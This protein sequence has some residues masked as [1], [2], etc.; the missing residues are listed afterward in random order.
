MNNNDRKLSNFSTLYFFISMLIFLVFVQS[1]KALNDNI[2]IPHIVVGFTPLMIVMAFGLF[3][4]AVIVL[5]KGKVLL[6]MISLI[7][8]IR[9]IFPLIPLVYEPQASEFVGNYAILIMD[10]LI[11]LIAANSIVDFNGLKKAILLVFLLICVQTCVEAL[12]GTYTFFDDTYFY[13]NDLVIPVGGS[14]AIAAK[15]IP[16]F[17]FLYCAETGKKKRIALLLI[18]LISVIITKSRG[19]MIVAL[20]SLVIMH[21]WGKRLS[22]KT[23]VSFFIILTIALAAGIY[24]LFDTNI[25]MLAFSLS[26]STVIGRQDLLLYGISLFFDHPLLGNGFSDEVV[27]YNPHNYILYTLMAFGL[28]GL[29]LFCVLMF[30]VFKSFCG[31]SAD[32]FVRGSVCFLLCVLMEGLGEIVL[33]SYISDFML[34]FILGATMSRIRAI[35]L[36]Q[37]QSVSGVTDGVISI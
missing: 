5:R 31:Y 18:M 27:F 23:I 30:F 35:K 22:F 6:D 26:D 20:L 12:I 37:M 28:V 21:S 17:A 36:K 1:G 32:L 25:G 33:Y 7:M 11:Y 14:N 8:C 29:L 34:W 10:I 19:G 4:L 24:F 3:M 9:L 15:I 2:D 16:L 13:K